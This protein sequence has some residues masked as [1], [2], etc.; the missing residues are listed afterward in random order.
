MTEMLLDTQ[1]VVDRLVDA[2]VP[3]VQ[4]RAHAAVL[5]EVMGSV[6]E[7]FIGNFATKEDLDRAVKELK[8]DLR[9]EM[10]KLRGDLMRWTL[11]VVVAAGFIQ[12]ALIVGL[13]LKLLP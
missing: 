11:T 12:T 1:K 13:I 3:P 10:E 9:V 6:N 4:A 8:A 2:G 7:H 5:A